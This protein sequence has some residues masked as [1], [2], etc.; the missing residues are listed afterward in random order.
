MSDCEGPTTIRVYMYRQVSH[1]RAAGRMGMAFWEK[2][3]EFKILCVSTHTDS[4]LF[5]IFFFVVTQDAD[6]QV[7]HIWKTHWMRTVV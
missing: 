3:V 7:S 5:E 1:H 4:C 6:I 2:K